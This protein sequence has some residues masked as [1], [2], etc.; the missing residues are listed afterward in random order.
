MEDIQKDETY[1]NIPAGEKQQ[2]AVNEDILER[3]SLLEAYIEKNADQGTKNIV[4][5]QRFYNSG[6]RVDTNTLRNLDFKK[7]NSEFAEKH[8]NLLARDKGNFWERGDR[9]LATGA[10]GAFL[11]GI[12][13]QL[14]GALTGGVFGVLFGLF[15]VSNKH[16]SE[17]E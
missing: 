9:A 2:E 1:R 3:L 16:N 17:A 12:I 6:I 13:A 8:K 7:L 10:G 4:D 14:P 15:V 5:R 11:G